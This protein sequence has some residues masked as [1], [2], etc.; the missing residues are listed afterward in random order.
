MSARI[1]EILVARGVVS[2]AQLRAALLAG[3]GRHTR[4]RI[5]MTKE[6]HDLVTACRDQCFPSV[7][8]DVD[9]PIE[10]VAREPAHGCEEAEPHRSR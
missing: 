9:E 2:A 6:R 1:G 10:L 5:C 4:G 3:R 7:V 8:I